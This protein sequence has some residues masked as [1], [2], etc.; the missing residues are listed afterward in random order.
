MAQLG[1]DIDDTT[2]SYESGSP[3]GLGN[4]IANFYIAFGLLDSERQQRITAAASS[5]D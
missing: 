5:P 4:H 1:Y 2:T 3:A